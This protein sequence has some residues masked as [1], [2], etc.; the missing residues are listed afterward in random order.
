M[1]AVAWA[2]HGLLFRAK[3]SLLGLPSS[4]WYV[5]GIVAAVMVVIVDYLAG[6]EPPRD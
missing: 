1:L 4:F 3:W 6:C 2:T 5:L